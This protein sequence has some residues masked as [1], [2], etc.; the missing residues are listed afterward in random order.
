MLD[1]SNENLPA[2]L[3]SLR[4]IVDE[5]EAKAAA[6]PATVAAFHQAITD[7][8]MGCCIG[9]TYAG[10]IWYRGS[11]TLH[12]STLRSNLLQSAW[13]HVYTG[14][15]LDKIAPASDRSK[16]E[17]AFKDPAPFTI[18]N[19]RAT[20]GKY[21]S[22]PRGHILRGLAECFAGLDPAFKSHDRMKIGVKGLPKRIILSSVG[23]YGG[24]G[25]DRLKDTINALRVLNGRPHIEWADTKD[26]DGN[27]TAKGLQTLLA[28]A[29]KGDG[30]I[31]GL[32]LR[33]FS[34]GNGHLFFA[35][36]VL[37]QV[38]RALADYYGEVLPDCPEEVPQRAKGTAVAKDLQF[39]R[40]PAAAA[41][42]LV[43]R[44][45]P[46]D[47]ARIL[48]PSCG[49][50]A[51]LEALRRYAT[52]NRY[53]MRA[54]GIEYDAGRAEQARAK[55][56]GVMT[57]NFLQV[58]P[59]PVFD[60]VLMNPPFYGKHYQKHIEHGLKFL[61]PGGVLYAILPITAVTDHDYV[62]PGRGWDTWKDLPAGSFS[63]SGT[64]INTGIARFF[65]P[66]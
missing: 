16:F 18:D 46:R 41:D 52:K 37:L 48:E 10:S 28:E 4:E 9:G 23:E 26:A 25:T 34:N 42:D 65:A 31:D 14:L 5:Y 30:E 47:G 45:Y 12:E 24:W 61:K 20:F 19:I 38:N 2:R 66:K 63:E 50:G 56:F 8:E 6:I 27:V 17:L 13:R 3:R 64:N 62:D 51:I 53:N 43:E 7:A 60:F 36:D 57:A 33:R 39:Y 22:D 58:Q 35:P 15:N 59:D 29:K 40:T 54:T 21:I 49:D 1:T 55:G 11:P 44:A 32:T